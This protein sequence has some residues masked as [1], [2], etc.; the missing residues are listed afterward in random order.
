M[1]ENYQMLAGV[2]SAHPNRQVEGRIRLHK[3]I[4]LLQRIGLP[5]DYTFSFHFDGPYSQ[6]LHSDLKMI[7]QTGLGT[8]ECKLSRNGDEFF[9]LKAVSKA[10]LA[11][12]DQF[13]SSI[14]LIA[15]ADMQTLDF[16]S[17][18]DQYREMGSSHQDALNRVRSKIGQSH[19]ARKA[20]PAL[21]LLRELGLLVGARAMRASA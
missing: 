16:A 11:M 17:V 5:T 19:D 20:D 4:R 21:T 10:R 6:E 8:E 12:L 13:E 7:V 2:I 3:T 18:Y 15:A 1:L 9:I 14:G